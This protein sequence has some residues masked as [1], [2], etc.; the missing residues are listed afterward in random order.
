MVVDII[1]EGDIDAAFAQFADQRVDALVISSGVIFARLLDRIIALAAR[2]AVPAIWNDR[3]YPVAGGLMSY[4]ADNR[5]AYRQAAVYIGR[6]LKGAKPSDMPIMQPTKFDL[7]INLK[8]ANALGFDRPARLLHRR[9]GDR[10][11]ALFCSCCTCSGPCRRSRKS[12]CPRGGKADIW[13][14]VSDRTC[15]ESRTLADRIAAAQQAVLS[16]GPEHREDRP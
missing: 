14:H 16:F 2:H 5:D 6:I 10:I 13:G 12:L 1:S 7:V 15:T 11:A 3:P 8:T 4:G 9:R